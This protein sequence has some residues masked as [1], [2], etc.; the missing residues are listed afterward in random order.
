MKYLFCSARLS[1]RFHYL[2]LNIQVTSVRVCV[3]VN[4]F[5][6]TNSIVIMLLCEIDFWIKVYDNY[7]FWGQKCFGYALSFTRVVGEYVHDPKGCYLLSVCDA[8]S[9]EH[10]LC[11]KYNTFY[12]W[13]RYKYVCI[14]RLGRTWSK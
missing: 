1:G 6:M 10:Q 8:V 5:V 2:H 4:V 3:C 7:A 9:R 13:Y 14:Q 11:N 12:K